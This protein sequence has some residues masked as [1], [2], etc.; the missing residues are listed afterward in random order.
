MRLRISSDRGSAEL[1]GRIVGFS[2]RL[3]TI[4]VPQEF[5]DWSNSHYGRTAGAR[6][7]PSRLIIDVS[8]PGDVK[9][10][11]LDAHEETTVKLEELIGYFN[12]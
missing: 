10:K 7:D 12:K 8:S 6:A 3:N 1:Q 11:D 2:N 9:I 4:L 5:M